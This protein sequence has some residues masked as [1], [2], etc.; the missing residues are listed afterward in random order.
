[1]VFEHL[2]E[3]E[4]ERLYGDFLLH[5]MSEDDAFNEVYSMDCRM[6]SNEKGS[7]QQGKSYGLERMKNHDTY[8][9]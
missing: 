7:L 3:D 9:T 6:D 4:V 2:T 1:M 8:Y 5:G